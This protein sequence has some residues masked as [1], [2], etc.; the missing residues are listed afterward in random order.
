MRLTHISVKDVPP[1]KSFEAGELSN[2]IVLAGPNGVG[3]T[4]LAQAL[5]YYFQNP[6]SR[7]NIQLVIHATTA[8]EIKDWGKKEIDTSDP[9]DALRLQGILHKGR[10]RTKWRSSI[11]NFESDRSIQ[12]ITPFKFSWDIKDPYEENIGWNTTFEGL[13]SRFQDTLHSIFRKVQSQ[14]DRIAK[15]AEELMLQGETSMELNFKDPLEPFKR[16]FSQLLSPKELLSPDLKKTHLDYACEGKQFPVTTLSSGEQ[17]VVNIV[18]DFLLRRPSHSIVIFDEPELHLHPELSFKLMRTLETI[19]EK[20]QFIFCTHSPDI[21]TASLEHSVI[22]IAPPNDSGTNQAILVTSDDETNQA[23]R[24]LGQSIGIVALGRRIVLI[25]GTNASLDKLVYGSII[26]NKFPNLVL[27]PSGGKATIISFSTISSQV[28]EKTIWGV[29]FFMLCDGDTSPSSPSEPLEGSR[30]LDRF[31]VLPRYH[32]ENYFLDEQILAQIFSQMESEE[33][34]LISPE[35]ILKRLREIARSTISYAVSLQ[36]STIFR[37]QAGNIDLMAKDCHNRSKEELL[38]LI[39]G[40]A[41]EEQGR[42]TSELDA[43]IINQVVAEKFQVLENSLADGNNLWKYL[44]P[45]R[46]IIKIFASQARL[47]IGRL[48][49]LYLRE[50]EKQDFGVFAEV[51]EIFEHFSSFTN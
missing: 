39:S 23:L 41:S 29:D 22:F 25:E 49:M 7:K 19:G 20:N 34:W 37:Q 16:A 10:L 13:K 14:R 2:I 28:L 12:K 36:V 44:I 27:V 26:K 50:A 33:S 4:R 5:L 24:L 17:E 35:E 38:D 40:R 15:K 32:L 6:T 30:A 9:K 1:I 46:Q 8:E 31:R 21:I 42:I 51:I 48:K 43:S 3:K 11:I 45:G 47:D 18:F